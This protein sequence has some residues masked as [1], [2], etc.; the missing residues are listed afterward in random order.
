MHCS[1]SFI[2]A[3]FCYGQLPPVCYHLPL[4][5]IDALLENTI[6][7]YDTRGAQLIFLPFPYFTEEKY[8]QKVKGR[9]S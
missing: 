9:L 7:F 3:L 8:D 5:Q 1:L 4:F 6:S 2:L